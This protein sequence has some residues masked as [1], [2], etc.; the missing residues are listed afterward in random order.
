M[1]RGLIHILEE[2][3]HLFNMNIYE[4]DIKGLYV[5]ESDVY[6]DERGYFLESFS[7]KYFVETGVNL[8]FVQDNI[9]KS[10]KGVLRGLHYQLKNPQGKMVRCI[11]GEVLDVCVD[12]R[13]NS[14]TFG[15]VFSKILNDKNHTSLYIPTGFAHGFCGLS[16]EA[17][18]HYKCTDYYYPN[19]SYGLLWSGIDLEWPIDKPII[20]KKDKILPTLTE[21]EEKLLPKYE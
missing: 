20:S 14:P 21:Q 15:K 7:N 1:R 2:Y 6:S 13:K 3:F 11:S 12:I 16:D 19:D 4:A 17:V 18:F 8:N 10:T 5:I 9:S